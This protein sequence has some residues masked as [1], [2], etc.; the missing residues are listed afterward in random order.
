MKILLYFYKC[1]DYFLERKTWY[2]KF[3][4]RRKTRNKKITSLLV[5]KNVKLVL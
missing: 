1:E 3:I 5:F 4:D 2:N